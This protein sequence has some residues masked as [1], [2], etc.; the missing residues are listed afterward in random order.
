MSTALLLYVTGG[1]RWFFKKDLEKFP[2]QNLAEFSQLIYGN[3]LV[4]LPTTSEVG[5]KSAYQPSTGQNLLGMGLGAANI[6]GMGGGL[7]VTLVVLH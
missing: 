6:Y 1:R 7:V 3:P 5:T 4:N 2:K